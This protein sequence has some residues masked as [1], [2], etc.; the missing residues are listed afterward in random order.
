MADWKIPFLAVMTLASIAA[1][2]I[3]A[4]VALRK[5]AP[6]AAEGFLVALLCLLAMGAFTGGDAGFHEFRDF[7]AFSG[8]DSGAQ[9]MGIVHDAAA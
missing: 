8:N 4:W 6:L 9:G 2:G 1:Q 5:R 3:L 7:L